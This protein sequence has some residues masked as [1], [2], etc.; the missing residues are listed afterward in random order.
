MA[1][2]I[3]MLQS[4]RSVVD[5]AE[6]MLAQARAGRWDEVAR[7]ARSIG[8]T[9]TAIDDARR[10][11]GEMC[12]AD[13]AERVRLLARLVRIDAEVRALRQ[14]WTRRLDAMLGASPR[15]ASR[16]ATTVSGGPRRPR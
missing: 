11:A 8:Q 7:S 16:D 3:E 12:P 9:T 5:A 2:G 13:E 6:A 14:P 4:Y 15:H 10:E 1:P